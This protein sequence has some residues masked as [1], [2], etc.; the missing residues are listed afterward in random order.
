MKT[1]TLN[2]SEPVYQAFQQYAKSQDRTT[3]ELVREAM[4]V[5]YATRIQS[6]TSLR[7]IKP[8]NLGKVIHP[9]SP[10]DDL[11]AEMLHD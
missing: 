6:A 2:V 8:L 7:D 10:K 4:A 5:Y 1:V 3:S 11:L 9:L